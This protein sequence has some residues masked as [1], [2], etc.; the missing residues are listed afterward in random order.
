M[1]TISDMEEKMANNAEDIIKTCRDL[2]SKKL[3]LCRKKLHDIPSS[4]FELNHLEFLYL[5]G[6]SL[7]SLPD[8]LFI[9][10]PKLKWLDLRKNKL[11]S[12]PASIGK[13]RFLRSLLLE[14]NNLQKLPLELGLLKSLS[15]LHVAENPLEF[16]PPSVI[17]QGTLEILAYLRKHLDEKLKQVDQDEAGE[18]ESGDQDSQERDRA[19]SISPSTTESS[20]S[21]KLPPIIMANDFKVD[22][23][24][25]KL[26]KTLSLIKPCETTMNVASF[27]GAVVDEKKGKRRK[28]P[29][30][31]QR[32]G[33]EMKKDEKSSIDT[34][35]SSVSAISS[36]SVSSK[37]PTKASA[38]RKKRVKSKPKTEISKQG[39]VMTA[40]LK[41]TGTFDVNYERIEVIHR[42]DT[43]ALNKQYKEIISEEKAK[44]RM[45]QELIKEYPVCKEPRRKSAKFNAKDLAEG[46]MVAIK[47]ADK[48]YIPGQPCLGKIVSLPADKTDLVLVHYY[49]GSYEGVWRPMMS[50]SSPYL[51]RVV[52]SMIVF[53]F[54]LN[55]DSTMSADTIKKLKTALEEPTEQ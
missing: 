23:V 37:S 18:I 21:T 12:L 4:I 42:Q 16:P 55:Q 48:H 3:D 31:A 11:R 14:G 32:K 50:R 9:S 52:L 20:L 51:R 6:N 26:E 7:H 54:E 46:D 44:R 25:D 30:K 8:E 10:L 19:R 27:E 47:V 15:G 28:S 1:S 17:E 13:L 34:I 53:K 38:K 36:R 5:E 39:N 22:A 24:A 2:K 33:N 40:S 35:D 29:E 43:V 49:S 45:V 41:E